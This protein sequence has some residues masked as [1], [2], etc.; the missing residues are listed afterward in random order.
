[1]A[2]TCCCF[3]RSLE[4]YTT[5]IWG[6]VAAPPLLSRSL[7]RPSKTICCTGHRLPLKGQFTVDLTGHAHKETKK[8]CFICNAGARV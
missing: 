3:S 7:P 2:N 8:G 6:E 4:P 1:M 5:M